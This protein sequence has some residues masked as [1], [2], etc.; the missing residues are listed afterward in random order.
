L[1]Q[2]L[3]WFKQ[4]YAQAN[5]SL[6]LLLKSLTYFE[7]AEKDPMPDMLEPLSFEE[8]KRFFSGEAPRLL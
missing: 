6:V 3:E 5:Y 7:D 2:V 8:V 4:K 1:T